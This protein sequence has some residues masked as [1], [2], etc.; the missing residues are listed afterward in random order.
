ME[1]ARR[2]PCEWRAPVYNSF[3]LF[4]DVR[5]PNRTRIDP[6]WVGPQ[7]LSRMPL[8]NDYTV[9]DGLNTAGYRWLRRH[10]GVDSSTGNDP[11]NNR[12]HLSA[13]VDYQLNTH[14]KLTYT[15]SR[16]KDWGVTG[17]TDFPTFRRDSSARSAGSRTYTPPPGP[18]QCPLRC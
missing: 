18:R 9:G 5:D 3:N 1:Y 6:I 16:E 14:N 11:N 12:D 17:Q 8:P 13:R 7:Y 4:G 15:M 10:P 2:Q